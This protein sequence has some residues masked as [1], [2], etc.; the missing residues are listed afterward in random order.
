MLSI[1]P[2]VVESNDPSGPCRLF[3]PMGAASITDANLVSALRELKGMRPRATEDDVSRVLEDNKL[4]VDAAKSFLIRLNVLKEISSEKRLVVCCNTVAVARAF[5]DYVIGNDAIDCDVVSDAD[6]I[7]RDAYIVYIQTSYSAENVSRLYKACARFD[8][9]IILHSYFVF[10]HFVIDGFY[11]PKMGL[12]DHFSGLHNLAGLNRNPDFKPISWADY[13]L[14][15]EYAVESLK[16]PTFDISEIEIHAAL[17][18]LYTRL[19]PFLTLGVAPIFPDDLS[20]VIE[21]NLDTGRV[22]RHRG[23]HSVFS[24]EPRRITDGDR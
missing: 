2:I 7:T 8:S 17:H 10:R 21:L 12:P 19:R 16:V 6:E 18:L 14:S 23:V 11:T 20:T 4:P 24:P 1:S 5:A 22:E 13:F 3:T 9:C 15:D